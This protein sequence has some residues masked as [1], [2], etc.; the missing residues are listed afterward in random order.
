MLTHISL[1]AERAQ[2]LRMIA[3]AKGQS[4]TE[5]VAELV[6]G[7]IAKGTITAD[8]PGFDVEN[9]GPEITIRTKDGF[10]ASVPTNQGP[11]LADLMRDSSLV[12]HD[13]ERKQRWIEGIAALTGVKLRRVGNGL[14]IVSPV[15]GLEQSLNIDVAQDLAGQIERAAE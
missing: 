5:V 3:K 2:Q 6:R 10:E 4:V 7:E 9:T 11:T 15:T 8:V 1:P 12:P 14:K 13:P